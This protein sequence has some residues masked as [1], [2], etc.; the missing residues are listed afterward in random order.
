MGFFDFLFKSRKERLPPDRLKSRLFVAAAAGDGRQ[1]SRLC[2]DYRAEIVAAFPGWQQVPESVRAN[3]QQ[4]QQYAH[5]LI[6]VAQYFAE[7]LGDPSLLQ[8]MSGPPESNPLAKWEAVLERVSAQMQQLEFA[9]SADLLSTTISEAEGCQGPG[10]DRYLPILLGRLGEAQFQ[11]GNAAE[12]IVTSERALALCEAAGDAEGVAAYQGNLYEMRRYLGESCEP[13][14]RVVAEFAGQRYEIDEL[15]NIKDGSCRFVFVRNRLALGSSS[16]R[17]DQGKQ[18]GEAGEFKTALA[19]F[20]SAAA[21]DPFDPDPHYQAAFTL[22]QLRRY[23]EAID[24][25][26]KTEKLAPG[27]FHCR[28]GRFIAEQLASDHLDRK[29]WRLLTWLQDSKDAPAAKID[30]AQKALPAFPILAP[31]HLHLGLNLHAVGR[32]AE[33]AAAAVTG[34]ACVEDIDTQTRLYLLV[35]LTA[36]DAAER[37]DNLCNAVAGNGNLVAAATAQVALRTL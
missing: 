10:V 5:G 31:L 21:A 36:E 16:G 23:P 24:R 13:L 6:S 2:L 15:P 30:A 25:Y 22:V 34:L 1:L 17:V 33:A 7:G 14:L 20:D 12:A 35:G 3:P 19:L 32:S 9:E 26:R 28:S 11:C 4:V 29:T 8:G 37:S 27:W 18:A